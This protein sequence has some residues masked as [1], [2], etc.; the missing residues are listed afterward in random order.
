MHLDIVDH[1]LELKDAR[2]DEGR[3]DLVSK[4]LLDL[5]GEGEFDVALS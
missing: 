3:T 2:P 5:F 1:F 4:F